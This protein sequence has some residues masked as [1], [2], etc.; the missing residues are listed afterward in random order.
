M[1]T[2]LQ[3]HSR[4][5]LALEA[6]HFLADRWLL[7]LVLIF[8]LPFWTLVVY[9]LPICQI[10]PPCTLNF[11]WYLQHC[12]SAPCHGAPPYNAILD[13][14]FHQT[15]TTAWNWIKIETVQA[16]HL[17]KHILINRNVDF[18]QHVFNYLVEA[19]KCCSTGMIRGFFYNGYQ[20]F[21]EHSW[22]S[23]P[24]ITTNL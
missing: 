5:Q 2:V 24:M 16:G 3:G 14:W 21:V 17:N 15:V 22:L 11:W 1:F 13:F 6:F 8:E 10:S 12:P 20:V 9:P 7:S 23:W 18:L 19:C 4:F